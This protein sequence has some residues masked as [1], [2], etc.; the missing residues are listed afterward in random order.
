MKKEHTL[1]NEEAIDIIRDEFGDLFDIDS[2]VRKNTTAEY[3]LVMCLDWIIITELFKND[4]NRIDWKLR[5]YDTEEGFA[6][7]GESKRNAHLI[8]YLR[9]NKEFVEFQLL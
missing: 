1:E 9:E 6:R 5:L 8:N 3:G 4:R 2:L 7:I